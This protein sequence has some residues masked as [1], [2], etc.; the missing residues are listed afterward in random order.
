MYARVFRDQAGTSFVVDM[1]A[2]VLLLSPALHPAAIPM[3]GLVLWAWERPEDLRFIDSATTGVAYLAATVDLQ[4]DGTARFHFRQQ[5][6][7]I[8]KDT[9]TIAVVRIESPPRYVFPD[10]A[11]IAASLAQIS[12]RQDL[13]GL[14]IDYDARVSERNFYRALLDD[15][16]RKTR[17]PIGI[18]ALASWCDG[19]QWLS[20][21][22][23]S[24]AVPMFFRMGPGESKGMS[25]RAS[26]C[27]DSI[28]LSTDEA[29]PAGRPK[30][31]RD[32]A[33]VYVFN[34]HP[35]TK[36]DYDIVVGRVKDWK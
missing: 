6:L 30:G 1:V 19:D 3:P 12:Q 27:R 13:K 31:L 11:L 9:S 7:R 21:Q 35:W 32:A 5:P 34:P 25:V 17:L 36:S 20:G 29:W 14:Q 16:R 18:T 8:P 2:V 10:P 22:P 28:G 23:L 4:V 15:L 33:R 26:G 24:E